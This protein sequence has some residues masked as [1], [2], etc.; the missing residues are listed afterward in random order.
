VGVIR[1]PKQIHCDDYYCNNAA[2]SG[3]TMNAI[4]SRTLN[5]IPEVTLVF[6]V[7]KIAATT[8]GKPAA[9]QSP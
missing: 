5:K 4:S 1:I 9:T 2:E 8:L 6:W 7:I 3:R